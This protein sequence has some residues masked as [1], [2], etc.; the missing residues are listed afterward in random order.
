MYVIAHTL[1]R[2]NIRTLELS[3]SSGVLHAFHYFLRQENFVRRLDAFAAQFEV[4][5]KTVANDLY[6]FHPAVTVRPRI[7]LKAARKAYC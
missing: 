6:H 1:W 7:V 3:D 2:P 5:R 4:V